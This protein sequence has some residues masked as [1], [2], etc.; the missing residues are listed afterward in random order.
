M[1]INRSKISESLRRPIRVLLAVA[2]LVIIV[3]GTYSFYKQESQVDD[4]ARETK[5][6]CENGKIVLGLIDASVYATKLQRK[7]D[8]DNHR[9]QALAGDDAFLAQFAQYRAR[10]VSQ[11]KMC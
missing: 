11:T 7:D 9:F 3:S 10:Q 2:C 6:I 5:I 1:V 4:L 8:I